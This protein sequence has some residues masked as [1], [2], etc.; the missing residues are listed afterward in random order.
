MTLFSLIKFDIC[1]ALL[2][3]L[4]ARLSSFLANEEG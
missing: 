1:L 4:Q 3:Y 2:V